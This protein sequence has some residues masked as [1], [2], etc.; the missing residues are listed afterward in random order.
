MS[1]DFTT[2]ARVRRFTVSRGVGREPEK[3][4]GETAGCQRKFLVKSGGDLVYVR[5]NSRIGRIC[6]DCARIYYRDMRQIGLDG[7]AD[8]AGD[9]DFYFFTATAPL[10]GET[11]RVPIK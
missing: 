8:S 5:C 9:W 11:H 3:T 2:P 7:I 10:F 6:P 1:P 4:R